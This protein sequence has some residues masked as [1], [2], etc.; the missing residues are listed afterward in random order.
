MALGGVASPEAAS[1]AGIAF[2]GRLGWRQGLDNFLEVH[3]TPH[4]QGRRL[5]VSN[6]EPGAN[7]KIL[8]I[9]GAGRRFIKVINQVDSMND[10]K[11]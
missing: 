2:P 5:G 8:R 11:D 10:G 1:A 7:S 3:S 6:V 9:A 4:G